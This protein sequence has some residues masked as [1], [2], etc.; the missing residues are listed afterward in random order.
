MHPIQ[1]ALLELSEKENL[2]ALTL[3]GMGGRIGLKDFSP[4]KI[5]HHLDQLKKKGFL[6]IDQKEN[7]RPVRPGYSTGLLQEKQLLN[8]P[9]LGAANCGMPTLFAEEN[10]KGF[11]KISPALIKSK[12]VKSLFALQAD[13]LSMNKAK[14]D[15]K[16][17]DHGD[18]LIVDGTS[19]TPKTGDIVLS[20]IDGMANIKRFV[21]DDIND[22]IV[23]TSDSSF[24]FPSIYLHPEDD[25]MVNGKVIGVIKQPSL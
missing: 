13:G 8:I 7:I 18:Y 16:T 25:F 4:Q 5:K 14:V 3:R 6:V 12:N 10:L 9:I 21:K 23:L 11:L 17:I 19:F 2:S 1:K 24:Q 22:Q 15:G 20:I